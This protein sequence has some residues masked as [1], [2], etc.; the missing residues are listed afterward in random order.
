MNHVAFRRVSK[1]TKEIILKMLIKD[2]DNRITPDE[3][4]IHPFFVR[5]YNFGTQKK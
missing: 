1:E 3:I 5:K 4:L 2:P